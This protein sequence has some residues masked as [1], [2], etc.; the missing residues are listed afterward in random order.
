VGYY[1]GR[2]ALKG[3]DAI[4]SALSGVPHVELV[5]IAGLS[6]R[7]L[8]EAY[9][10]LNYFVAWESRE[11]WSN[12]AAEALSCGVPVVTNGVGCEP[13][14]DRCITVPD[15]RRF[16][17]RPLHEFSWEVVCMK[18]ADIWKRDGLWK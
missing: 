3:E 2:G 12:T 5:P 7:D 16:F 13:F 8:V 14:L 15:L 10:S 11:G 18:L 1:A 4:V 17:E 6:H 9:S